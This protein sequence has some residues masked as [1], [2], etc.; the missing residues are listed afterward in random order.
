MFCSSRRLQLG[1]LL[2]AVLK[3]L[4]DPFAAQ[5]LTPTPSSP[6]RSSL[7]SP[8]FARFNTWGPDGDRFWCKH[9][10]ARRGAGFQAAGSAAG[11][12]ASPDHPLRHTRLIPSA[13]TALQCG[14]PALFGFSNGRTP[15]GDEMTRNERRRVA[16]REIMNHEGPHEGCPCW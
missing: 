4:A 10:V 16:D 11:S 2:C 14:A 6:F 3:D 7:R 8:P 9:D 15:V 1:K 5:D 12:L 13:A